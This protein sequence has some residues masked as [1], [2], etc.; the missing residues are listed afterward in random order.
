MTSCKRAVMACRIYRSGTLHARHLKIDNRWGILLDRGLD[1]WQRFDNN[2]AFSIESRLPEMR[3]V[4]A[5]ELTYMR[6]GEQ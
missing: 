1:N 5:F 4:K 3:C 6:A 2:D